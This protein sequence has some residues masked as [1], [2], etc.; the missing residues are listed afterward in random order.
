[1]YE[2]FGDIVGLGLKGSGFHGV[3]SVLVG[4]IWGYIGI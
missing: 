3:S 2:F 1:M 4:E